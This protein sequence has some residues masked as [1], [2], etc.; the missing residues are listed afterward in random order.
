MAQGARH[1]ADGAGVRFRA[2][3]V[4]VGVPSRER[5]VVPREPRAVRQRVLEREVGCGPAVAVLEGEVR[6]E[7]VREGGL[8]V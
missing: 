1:V 7:E 4:V 3:V 2:V 8:P 5:L 6:G